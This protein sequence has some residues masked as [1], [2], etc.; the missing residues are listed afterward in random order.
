M[1]E[2]KHLRKR[3]DQVDEQILQSLSERAELCRSIGLVKEKNVLP[4]QDLPRENTVYA[5]IR[6]KAAELGLSP[7]HVEAIYRQIV[8][9]CSV[10]QDSKK[11]R[12]ETEV[13]N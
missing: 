2:I 8:A 5:H 3:I 10:V 12:N 6:E 7:Y 13:E 1:Q 11:V 9:M 4:I